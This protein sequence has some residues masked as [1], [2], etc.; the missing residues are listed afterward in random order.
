MKNYYSVKFKISKTG[1]KSKFFQ[2]IVMAQKQNEAIKSA[3]EI[4][5]DQLNKDGFFDFEVKIQNA[6]KIRTDFVINLNKKNASN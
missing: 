1:Y 3:S 2:G 4:L 5:K 6:N